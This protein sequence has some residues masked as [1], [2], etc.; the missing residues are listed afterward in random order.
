MKIATSFLR[1]KISI[2][3]DTQKPSKQRSI[4]NKSCTE[5]LPLFLTPRF[6][7]NPKK[8]PKHYVFQSWGAKLIPPT[9]TLLKKEPETE[10]PAL[11]ACHN[12][13]PRNPYK[14][15]SKPLGDQIT[16]EAQTRDQIL[17]LSIYIWELGTY[18]YIYIPLSSGV[19]CCSTS[20]VLEDLAR[21]RT[22]SRRE[23]IVNISFPG[24]PQTTPGGHVRV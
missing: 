6:G 5:N 8:G 1:Y 21:L 4:S 16:Q 12:S 11:T 23:I 9:S 3:W 18:I 2:S 24:L 22:P 15:R 20:N 13:R 7:R 14:P 10:S 17:L 19:I